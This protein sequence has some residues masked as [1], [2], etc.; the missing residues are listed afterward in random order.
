VALEIRKI[1]GGYSLQISPPHGREAWSSVEP[2][3]YQSLMRIS[4]DLGVPVQDFWDAALEAD[5][6]LRNS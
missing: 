4:S 6:E 3:S 2:L 5:P 1:E